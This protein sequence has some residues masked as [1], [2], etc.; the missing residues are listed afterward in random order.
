MLA[1]DAGGEYDGARTRVWYWNWWHHGLNN[2]FRLDKTRFNQFEGASLSVGLGG[3]ISKSLSQT[4]KWHEWHGVNT[5]ALSEY[6]VTLSEYS[7]IE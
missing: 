7:G 1:N 6:R 4:G 5:V 3:N 2:A